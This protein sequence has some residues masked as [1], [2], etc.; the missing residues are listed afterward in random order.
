MR[1]GWVHLNYKYRGDELNNLNVV[2]Y[3]GSVESEP[4]KPTSPPVLNCRYYLDMEAFGAMTTKAF[5]DEKVRKELDEKVGDEMKAMP[6]GMYERRW[7]LETQL[8]ECASCGVGTGQNNSELQ[9]CSG[10][11]SF[12][13]CCKEHQTADWKEKHKFVCL[14][15]KGW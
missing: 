15:R 14:K 10:C 5:S 11:R 7:F 2:Q 4:L 12:V 13:Y 3:L 9:K 8:Q 6:D 1:P